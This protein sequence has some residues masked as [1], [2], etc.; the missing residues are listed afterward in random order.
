MID[1]EKVDWVIKVVVVVLDYLYVLKFDSLDDFLENISF[2]D[3]DEFNINV[4]YNGEKFECV[5]CGKFYIKRIGFGSIF[6][7]SI[8]GNFIF[9]KKNFL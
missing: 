8:N 1:I 2:L 7:K 6:K 5:M 9:L 4:M 3:R